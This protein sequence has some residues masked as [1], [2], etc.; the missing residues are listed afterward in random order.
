MW[1]IKC[2]IIYIS[3]GC[4][5][6][7]FNIYVHYIVEYVF[8]SDCIKYIYV[9]LNWL[10][11]FVYWLLYFALLNLVKLLFTGASAAGGAFKPEIL[12]EMAKIN[13]RPII[14]AL[15]NPTSKAE[16]TAE[17]AYTNTEVCSNNTKCKFCILISH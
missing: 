9:P 5:T 12:Q 13:D 10:I 17:Q 11:L 6:N 2:G 4:P 15:S 7:K 14:F 8:Q 16:C 3:C 1:R